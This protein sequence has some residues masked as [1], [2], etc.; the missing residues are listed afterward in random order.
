MRF[1][2]A[3][4]FDDPAKGAEL[5]LALYDQGADIV[6][7][8]A[9]PTGE[10]VLAL[11]LGDLQAADAGVGPAGIGD[12]DRD[13]DLVG[14]GRVGNVHLHAVYSIEML[15]ISRVHMLEQSKGCPHRHGQPGRQAP[16]ACSG[17]C[18]SKRTI[19]IVRDCLAG[20]YR[21]RQ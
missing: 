10:G 15:S 16:V 9:G 12:G 18:R 4:T 21:D 1:S 17:F 6:Y 3:G 13:H 8:V 20:L 11:D 5:T 2:F 19:P 7:N 14:A